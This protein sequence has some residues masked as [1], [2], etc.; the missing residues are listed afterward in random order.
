MNC[1][2]VNADFPNG[3]K[4]RLLRSWPSLLAFGRDSKVG[5]EDGKV[6]N[7]RE[8]SQLRWSLMVDCWRGEVGGRIT[9]SKALSQKS[10]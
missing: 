9:S 3:S 5:N 7:R 8:G 4:K 6:S 1:V 2:E 10:W